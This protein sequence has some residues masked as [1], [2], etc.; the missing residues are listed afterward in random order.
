M[1]H[2]YNPGLRRLRKEDYH[3]V[4]DSLGYT[5]SSR[6]ELPREVLRQKTKKKKALLDI[7]LLTQP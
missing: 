4:E 1:T 3:E 2:A 5:M 6:P 7:S